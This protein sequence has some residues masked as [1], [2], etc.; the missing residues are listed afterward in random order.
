MKLP[1]VAY[2]SGA[3]ALVLGD[4]PSDLARPG[5][6]DLARHG[7]SGLL[8]WPAQ[9]V[10]AP[11][12]ALAALLDLDFARPDCPRGSPRGRKAMKNG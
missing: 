12:N 9:L 2:D 10:L 5:W 3:N 11:C 1:N 7:S 8:E 6:L 4:Q